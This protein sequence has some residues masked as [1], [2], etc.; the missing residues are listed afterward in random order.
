LSAIRIKC[1]HC[2][3]EM[4]V[5]LIVEGVQSKPKGPKPYNPGPE[6]DAL[7][8]EGIDVWRTSLRAMA[9]LLEEREIPNGSGGKRW[10]PASVKRSYEQALKRKRNKTKADT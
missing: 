4:R 1:P 3:E 6:V 10:Y 8:I 5:D 7:I 9:E 2:Y